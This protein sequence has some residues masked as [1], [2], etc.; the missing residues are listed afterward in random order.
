MKAEPKTYCMA[1][2][3]CPSK[4]TSWSASCARP[5]LNFWAAFMTLPGGTLPLTCSALIKVKLTKCAHMLLT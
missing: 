5:L 4:P 1:V 3:S 2:V